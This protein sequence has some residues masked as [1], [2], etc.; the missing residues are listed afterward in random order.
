M[1]KQESTAILC[2]FLEDLLVEKG[3]SK[4][5]TKEATWGVALEVQAR[6]DNSARG[7]KEKV[8]QRVE[9]TRW[10]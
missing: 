2:A 3:E 10:P 4:R 5:G 8:G 1:L 9:V 6:N 7:D